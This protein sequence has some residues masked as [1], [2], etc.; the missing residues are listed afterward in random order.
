MPVANDE[1]PEPKKQ[2]TTEE[3]AEF[4]QW[5]AEFLDFLHATPTAEEEQ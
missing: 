3:L 1:G 5:G 4:A 2:A